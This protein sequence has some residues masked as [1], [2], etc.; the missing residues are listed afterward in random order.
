LH[1]SGQ[2]PPQSTPVSPPFM[3]WSMQLGVQ[4]PLSHCCP[5]Q[6][7]ATLHLLPGA[8]PLPIVLQ[9]PPQST[10]VSLPLST[11]SMHVGAWHD[12]PPHTPLVQS[13]LITHCFPSPHGAQEPPQ[14][15]SVSLPSWFASVHVAG[16]PL[17][18]LLPPIPELLLHPLCGYRSQSVASSI[19]EL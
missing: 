8:Q 12:A 2:P 5:V 7:A 13:A 15:T 4:V 19:V 14:S 17:L 16:M 9:S 11:P 18:E 3:V 6:S 10:S 1:K